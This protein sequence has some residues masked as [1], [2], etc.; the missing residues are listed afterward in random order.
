MSTERHVVTVL[1][2]ERYGNQLLEEMGKIA[3]KYPELQI[4]CFLHFNDFKESNH[5]GNTDILVLHIRSQTELDE[6]LANNPIKWVHSL[7]AGVDTI[8]HSELL[9]SM[10]IPLTNAKGAYDRGIAEWCITSMLYFQKN[11][12]LLFEQQKNHSYKLFQMPTLYRTTLVILGYGSI[13][14]YVAKLAKVFGMRIIGIKQTASE[15]DEYAEEIVEIS[16]LHEFLPQADF[17]VMALPKHSLT[18]DIIG[19]KELSLLKNSA[20]LINVGRGINLDEG[21]LIQALYTRTIRGA[22]LDVFKN[23]P[24]SA[25]SRLWDTPNILLTPHNCAVVDN[26]IELSVNVFEKHLKEFFE[27]SIKS[28]VDFNKGY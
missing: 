8:I 17:F 10:N 6:S 7:S 11:M 22:A 27:G 3:L 12:Q 26:V 16:R 18:V 24:L 13:G 4:A 25:D 15:P 19:A 1:I 2:F 20:V 9:R 14:R 5:W 21:A 23:E 28:S